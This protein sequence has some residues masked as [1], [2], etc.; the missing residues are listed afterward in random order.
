MKISIII[1]TINEAENLPKLLMH[2]LQH[3]HGVVAEILVSDGGSTDNTLALVKEFGAIA[4]QA[5]QSGRAA[6]MHYATQYAT[7]DI[8]YFV[9]AD[10]LPPPTYAQDIL[11]A[12]QKGNHLGRYTTQFDT[13]TLLLRLNAWF[14]R[15][16][17]FICLGGDQTLFITRESYLASGGFNTALSIME[18]FEFVPRVRKQ[19]K[20]IILPGK[21]T[22]SARKYEGRSWL[23]VQLANRK[24]VRMFKRGDSA[25]DIR[26]T[27]QRMLNAGK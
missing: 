21:T 11:N 26:V 1:P 2:L 4:L 13:N 16:D 22:V 10:T 6:Q 20:Y 5:P 25:D 15:F 9:H 24:A 3:A 14:T 27:Y 17:W 12:V 23:Q 18:E 19:Y 8:F 7:G